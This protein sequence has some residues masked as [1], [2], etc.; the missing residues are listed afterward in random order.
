M[1]NRVRL[2][3]L[4]SVYGR[5]SDTFIRSEVAV[6]RSLGHEVRTFSIRRPSESELVSDEIRREQA[7]TE[8]VLEVGFARLVA[9]TLGSAV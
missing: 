1:S 8:A 5:A 7:E 4:T 6:L 3:Y 9:S 2:G